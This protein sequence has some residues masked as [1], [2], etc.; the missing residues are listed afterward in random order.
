MSNEREQLL[1]RFDELRIKVS[2]VSYPPH[3]SVREGKALRGEKRSETSTEA[4]GWSRSERS[5]GRFERRVALPVAV[6]ESQASATF[7]NGVLNVTLPKQPET[8]PK[9]RTIPVKSA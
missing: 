8:K 7:K 6:Q 4:G 3:R 2:T 5:Y 1:R 9:A